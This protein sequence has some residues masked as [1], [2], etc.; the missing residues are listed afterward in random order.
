MSAR[1]TLLFGVHAH[2][3]A[4]N[5]PE[6]LEQAHERCYRPFLETLHRYPE[7]RFAL[8]V[9]GPLLDFLL[10][11]FPHDMRLLGDMAARGQ[12]ELFGGGETEP[13]LAAIPARDRVA[14]VR[15]FS[16]RLAEQFGMAPEGAWL[17]ERVWDANV[18]PALAACGIRYVTVDD[19]HFRC[20]GKPLAELGARFTTEEDGGSLDLYPISEALRYRLPFAPPEEAIACI[21]AMPG[22]AIYFDDIEKFGLWPET[23]DWVYGRRWLERFVEGV[24]GSPKIEV[25]TYREHYRATATRGIVYLPNA[26]YFEMNEWT[27]PAEAA[28]VY[29]ALVGR[30][31]EAGRYEAEKPFLRGGVWRNFLSRYPEANWMHKRMLELSGRLAAL[32]AAAQTPRMR[33]LLHLAQANDAYWHGLFGGLYLPHLRRAVYRALIELEAL[34][35]SAVPRPPLARRDFDLDGADEIFLRSA[36]LQAIV[37]LDGSATVVELDC[38]RLAQN[39]GDT[40][41]RHAEHYHACVRGAP[42]SRPTAGGIAS[43][44]DR[45]RSKHPIP[46]EDLA[47]DGAG[48]TL[49]R[50]SLLDREGKRHPVDNYRLQDGE[51]TVFRARAGG[52]AL[53][54]EIH[55]SGNTLRARYRAMEMGGRLAIE[56]NLA[57]PSCDGFAGRYFAGGG[58]PGGFGQPL[59]IAA[60]QELVL[61]DRFMGG[62]LRIRCD[63]AA[64]LDSR[65]LHTVSQSEDG[66]ERVMQCVT[67]TLQWPLEESGSEI[68]VTLEVLPDRPAPAAAV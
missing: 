42:W 48:R 44:H 19:Y 37:K 64:V 39:F 59:A 31:K 8:H 30:E 46:E 23:H 14:Q 65:P 27:L 13:V 24:L 47:P 57:M 25:R 21:E 10:G 50:D 18:V 3:P 66:F 49:F 4:G 62:A 61:D 40:L 1:A 17:T 56:I 55:L 60:A 35:D 20:A 52:G 26:S 2:Q 12:V 33:R 32:P 54:K 41:R 11:R 36:E 28:A 53:A 63:P 38:Y 51:G 67:V 9:S 16:R 34:L 58:I 68:A 22:A 29:A 5:F 6:V 43:A 15:A 45:A 7:F